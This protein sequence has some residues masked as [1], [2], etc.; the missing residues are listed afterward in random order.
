M[1]TQEQAQNTSEEI[2]IEDIAKFIKEEFLKISLSGLFGIA[3]ALIF[4]FTLGKYEAKIIYTNY[5]GIDIPRL[6]AL[7]VSLPKLYEESDKSNTKNDFLKSEKLWETSV[8]PNILIKKADGKDLLDV[9]ALT[10]ASNSIPT[11]EIVGYGTSKPKAIQN[12]ETISSFFVNGS[13][14][15]QLRDLIRNYD[16]RSIAVVSNAQKKMSALEIESVYLEKRIKNL[17]SLK[18][19]F[20]NAI[21]AGSQVVDAKDSGA[22]YL[23]ISTQIIAATTDLNGIQEQLARLK[24]EES[25]VKVYSSF[26]DSGKKLLTE[27]FDP[28]QLIDKLLIVIESIQKSIPP[29]NTIQI[30]AAESIKVDLKSIQTDNLYGLRQIGEI[31]VSYPKHVKYL[32]IG[33]FAGLMFGFIFSVALR[34]KSKFF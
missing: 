29:S 6:K 22:K 3:I 9:S 17:N 32:G 2:S 28:K 30:N 15:L 23:P 14:Y 21:N 25:Q 1:Q 20:P 10:K 5:S 16:L 27:T 33:L 18:N 7:Q 13:S 11:I 26:A 19:Q 8:K 34:F 4:S 24:D 12:A 31:D